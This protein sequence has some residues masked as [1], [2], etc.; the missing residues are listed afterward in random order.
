MSR[1]HGPW[2]TREL[3]NGISTNTSRVSEPTGGRLPIDDESREPADIL[4]PSA[5]TQESERKAAI[6]N[7]DAFLAL[8]TNA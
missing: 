7:I 5:L 2:S 6:S 8:Q 3:G 1:R 4:A